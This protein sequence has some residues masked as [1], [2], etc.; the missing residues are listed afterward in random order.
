M[1][2]QAAKSARTITA[3]DTHAFVEAATK[4]RIEV[5][6]MA[7]LKDSERLAAG[8]K[9]QSKAY[10]DFAAHQKN[11]AVESVKAMNAHFASLSTGRITVMFR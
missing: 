1:M 6:P 9:T 3:P 11:L 5:M 7:S 4:Q 2:Q 8:V 10:N